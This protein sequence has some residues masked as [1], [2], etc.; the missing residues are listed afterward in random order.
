[1]TP[2]LSSVD[3]SGK[4]A[5]ITGGTRGIGRAI[6]EA[7]LSAGARVAINGRNPAKG[8]QALKEMDA[9]DRAIFFAGDVQQQ[10]DVNK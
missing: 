3:L 9:G 4:V 6:A 8:E 2:N 7:F 5:A 1:M 10:T